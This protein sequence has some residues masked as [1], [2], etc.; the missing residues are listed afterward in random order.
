MLITK[1]ASNNTYEDE[2]IGPRQ[3]RVLS[4]LHGLDLV[5]ELLPFPFTVT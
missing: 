3:F 5:I 2:R 4:L 1:P